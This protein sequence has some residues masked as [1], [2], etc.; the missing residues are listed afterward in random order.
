MDKYKWTSESIKDGLE[1]FNKEN[2][3]FPTALE[4]DKT[5][6][7]PSSRQI[8]R[9]F[10]GLINFRK[11]AGHKVTDFGSGTGRSGIASRAGKRGL[12]GE[13]EVE[14]LLIKHFGEE[15]V[16]IEKRWGEYKHRLDFFVYNPKSNFAVDVI[17]ASSI[18]SLIVNL[19]MKIPRY[20]GFPYELYFVV[21]GPE[22]TQE[23]LDKLIK[24]KK[25]LFLSSNQ[26][27]VSQQAFDQMISVYTR[28]RIK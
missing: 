10:G 22:I 23:K 7:L 16:H 21:I 25:K 26:H 12:S 24:N 3:H 17:S 27:L 11:L 2:G 6:Y 5:T 8:Q 19:N 14:R 18:H 1:R 13:R 20:S 4:I 15:F 9:R 28:L